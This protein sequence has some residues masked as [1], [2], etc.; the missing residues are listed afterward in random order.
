MRKLK[1]PKK[2]TRQQKEFLMKRKV[3]WSK[4]LVLD[5]NEYDITLLNKETKDTKKIT[6]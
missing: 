2:P 4:Y 6:K 5:D 3:D 1:N